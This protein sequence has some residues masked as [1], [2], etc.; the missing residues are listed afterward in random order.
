MKSF[1]AVEQDQARICVG[2]VFWTA[3]AVLMV[4]IAI[5]VPD[6]RPFF[7]GGPVLLMVVFYF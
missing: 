7:L 1:K 2:Y 4:G 6:A 3:A 5:R